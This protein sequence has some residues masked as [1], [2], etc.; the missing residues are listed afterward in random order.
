MEIRKL[1][2]KLTNKRNLML[3]GSFDLLF[4]CLSLV[5]LIPVFL[6]LA[7]LIYLESNGPII[8]DGVRMGK[9]GKK[10]KCY[11]FRSMY[12]DSEAVL[13][14][15]LKEHPQAL[16]QWKKYHKLENDPRITPIGRFLRK[17]SLDELP[18]FWN[19][20]MGDMSIVGP[21]PY[22]PEEKGDMGE[23]YDVILQIRPGLTGVW[24]TNGRSNLEFSR[25]LEMDQ[26][27]VEHWSFGLDLQL[28]WKTVGIVL[29]AQGAR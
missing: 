23:A 21:R 18:Q 16:Q 10:F 2:S 3:K 8:Y 17:T 27:Y 1:N 25:R 11:K 28:I 22:L 14:Q 13:A 24:Q 7:L 29:K 5:L 15:Y 26:W 12:T 4:T 20:L 6:I 9:D 19:V